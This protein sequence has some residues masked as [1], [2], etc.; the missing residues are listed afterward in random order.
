MLAAGATPGPPAR[1]G[2]PVMPTR[3]PVVAGV[4][5]YRDGLTQLLDAQGGIQVVG[6]AATGKAALARMA[7][8]RPEV[9]LLEMELSDAAE[10]IHAVVH[11]PDPPPVLALG[12]LNSDDCI[13]ACLEAGAA[14]YVDRDASLD[15]LLERLESAA[16]GEMRC[17]PTVA[18]SLAR[19]LATVVDGASDERQ[20]AQLTR[21]ESEIVA[22]IE[23]GLSNKQIA[24][25]LFIEVSTV[26]NHV[27]HI[28]EKLN[29]SRR[30]EAAARARRGSLGR[31]EAGAVRD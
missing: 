24:R 7:E 23:L 31:Q 12:M 4:R 9:V 8:S 1:R 30:G 25:R 5:L 10:T 17:S 18:A 15:E 29:V 2:E 28:L 16:R 20:Q 21:R 6:T 27:H 19:R 14:G 11:S 13:V 26:K 3:V 22:L